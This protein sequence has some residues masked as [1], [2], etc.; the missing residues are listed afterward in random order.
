MAICFIFS[1]ND[2]VFSWL[3][4]TVSTPGY[5]RML[6]GMNTGQLCPF[7]VSVCQEHVFLSLWEKE[8]GFLF[9]PVILLVAPALCQVLNSNIDPLV[10]CQRCWA[11]E[12]F[13]P[14]TDVNIGR[15]RCIYP[16]EGMERILRYIASCWISF[17]C[18]SISTSAYP[19]CSEP[20]GT[21]LSGPHQASQWSSGFPLGLANSAYQWKAGEGSIYSLT[22]IPCSCSSCRRPCSYAVYIT[23]PH[24]AIPEE[25]MDTNGHS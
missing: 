9:S 20:H 18:P 11:S 15:E 24:W 3:L 12:L 22:L 19:H 7:A 4:L 17:L 6:R 16:C 8:L 25:R 10:P 14:V 5:Q 23:E 2:L 21:H 13:F 1:K